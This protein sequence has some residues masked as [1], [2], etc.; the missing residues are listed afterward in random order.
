[1]STLDELQPTQP[2]TIDGVTILAAQRTWGMGEFGPCLIVVWRGQPS[3][4]ALLQINERIFDLSQRRPGACAYINV[5]EAN[6]PPPTAPMRKLAMTGVTRPGDALTCM[7]AV[8]EGHEFR[9]AAVRAIITGMM[10]LRPQVRPTKIFK[11]TKEMSAWVRNQLPDAPS[12]IDK[13]IV[14]AAEVL[15]G[16]LP[17]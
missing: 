4:Q 13:Q 10:M 17:T 11:N 6:S 14:R 2:S 16:Q 12:D 7:A 3:E 1:M 9:T 15:R 8:M 5:I